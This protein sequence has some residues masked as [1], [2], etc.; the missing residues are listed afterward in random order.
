MSDVVVTVPKSFGWTR[1]LEE[2]D[3]PGEPWSGLESYFHLGGYPPRD[4]EV[5]DRVYVVFN[6]K[7]RGYAP[8][9]RII[10]IGPR[11]YALARRGGAVATT[12]SE[13]IK[14]FRGF[15]YRWWDY[16]L[17]RLFPNWRLP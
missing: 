11:R 13:E 3:L 9:N 6:G 1:W 17:E 7:L 5:G 14:G 4:L 15:R 12:I 2:G 10:H 8:L 16:D